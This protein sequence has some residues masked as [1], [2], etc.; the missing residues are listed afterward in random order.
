MAAAKSKRSGV[1]VVLAPLVV[2]KNAEGQLEYLYAGAPVDGYD[3][4]DT[5]RLVDLGFVGESSE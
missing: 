5:A 2:I 1:L 4:D 3:K